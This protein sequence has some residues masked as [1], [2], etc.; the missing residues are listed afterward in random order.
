MPTWL[1]LLLVALQDESSRLSVRVFL[2][3]AV[4]HVEARHQQ[5]VAAW[6]AR[7]QARQAAQQQ[8]VEEALVDDGEEEADPRPK[9]SSATSSTFC[10]LAMLR[11][12]EHPG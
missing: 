3:K 9:V 8:E 10:C 7:Q 11:L 6:D 2:A 4:L 5:A 12:L 1:Q